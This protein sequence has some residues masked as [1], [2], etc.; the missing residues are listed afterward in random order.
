MKVI[1]ELGFDKKP[2]NE[3]VQNQL[4]AIAQDT[5]VDWYVKEE[6]DTLEK[7][8]LLS[9]LTNLYTEVDSDVDS[10]YRTNHL[11]LAMEQVFD[12]LFKEHKSIN[13]KGRTI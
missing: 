12:F 13:K 6:E 9:L 7:E 11:N 8:E 5:S 4:N 2:T 10:N 1:I 3:E